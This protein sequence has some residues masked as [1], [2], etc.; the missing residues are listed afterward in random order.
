MVNKSS[1]SAD[2]VK[3]ILKFKSSAQKDYTDKNGVEHKGTHQFRFDKLK[4]D[5]EQQ[6]NSN[7]QGALKE[8]ENNRL[9]IDNIKILIRLKNEGEKC[10]PDIRD[11]DECIGDLDCGMNEQ[12]DY[13][14]MRI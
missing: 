10:N 4:A 5:I 9:I 3:T 13:V 11:P 1:T 7:L 2:Y 12:G 6:I 8:D 14:C